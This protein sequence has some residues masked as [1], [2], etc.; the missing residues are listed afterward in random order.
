ML[1]SSGIG[2]GVGSLLYPCDRLSPKPL[3]THHTQTSSVLIPDYRIPT[4][5]NRLHSF[6]IAEDSDDLDVL[7]NT[8][9]EAAIT[10][11][12]IHSS[13]FMD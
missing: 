11:S 10:Y 4:I 2:Q 8:L 12:E 13:T 6:I 5:S 7:K 9:M 1:Q 3:T